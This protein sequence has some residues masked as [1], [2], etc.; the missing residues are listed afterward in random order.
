MSL[1][2]SVRAVSLHLD[3]SLA[4]PLEHGVVHGDTLC[5]QGLK[6]FD[7][8][9]YVFMHVLIEHGPQ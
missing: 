1:F 8:S 5:V 2:G 7:F 6:R 9:V 4:L 3:Q